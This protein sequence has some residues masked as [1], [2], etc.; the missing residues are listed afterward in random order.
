MRSKENFEKALLVVITEY[1]D[2]MLTITNLLKDSQFNTKEK[3]VRFA[4]QLEEELM[5]HLNNFVSE[6][7]RI[8]KENLQSKNK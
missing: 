4:K 6:E 5:P 8:Q 3:R 1:R 2:S 7:E